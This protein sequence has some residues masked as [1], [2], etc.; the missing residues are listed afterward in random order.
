MS[1]LERVDQPGRWPAKMLASDKNYVGSEAC[2]KCH[3]T[4]SASFK[5]AEMSKA[6][7]RAAD[8]EVLRTHEGNAFDL[9]SYT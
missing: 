6:L 5:K 2:P 4:I 8:S 7:L 3:A 1:S 9:E